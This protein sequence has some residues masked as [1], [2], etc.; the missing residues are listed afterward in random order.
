MT[1]GETLRVAITDMPRV[2]AELFSRNNRRLSTDER[3][4]LRMAA[5]V[6]L[7]AFALFWIVCPPHF[8]ETL[9]D[10]VMASFAYG[11]DGGYSAHLLY[12]HLFIGLLIKGL[13]TV[14]PGVAWYAVVQLLPIYLSLTLVIFVLY[15]QSGSKSVIMPS[16]FVLVPFGY[17]WICSLQFTKTAGICLIAGALCLAWATCHHKRPGIKLLCVALILLGSMFRYLMFE[18]LVVPFGIYVA[19]LVFAQGNRSDLAHRLSRA[20]VLV[21]GICLLCVMCRFVNRALYQLDEGWAY[22]LNNNR[23]RTEVITY[24]FPDYDQNEELYE[25]L[26]MTRNDLELY[27][28]YGYGDPDNFTI[29]AVKA[30]VA[31]KERPAFAPQ[32]L[33]T[34][35]AELVQGYAE[36]G[37]GSLLAVTGVWALVESGKDRRKFLFVVAELLAFVAIQL[38]LYLSG[39]YLQSR[40]DLCYVFVLAVLFYEVVMARGEAMR[41][42]VARF[43]IV[44]MV[45]ALQAP[46]L[47]GDISAY[48]RDV[49]NGPTV[50]FDELATDTDHF[51]LYLPSW[52]SLPDK[53]YDAFEVH[54]PGYGSN[55]TTL[56]TWRFNTPIVQNVLA[57]WDLTNPYRDMLHR[58]DVLLLSTSED[59]L[60]KVVTHIQEHYDGSAHAELVEVRHGKY[61]IYRIVT[62]QESTYELGGEP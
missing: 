25:S 44:C 4:A 36:Y 57:R 30:L 29:D 13:L 40:V 10:A 45:C 20:L 7:E 53:I 60:Y 5:L 2:A 52:H 26:N 59:A 15:C 24:G 16:L 1:L 61:F 62:D 54:E 47:A 39:R 3:H 28:A 35:I 41:N 32:T 51:Y 48:K 17:Q 46:V 8:T 27:Q 19:Y 50:L 11:Y 37:F 21:V 43:A 49:E 12:I 22:S 58:D 9:D 33:L 23:L 55:M 18:M 34:G 14:M 42:Q 6:T 38:Y 31:A 56:G